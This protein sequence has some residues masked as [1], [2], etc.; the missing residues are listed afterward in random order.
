MDACELV[1]ED[2]VVE[3]TEG[4]PGIVILTV[5]EGRED[6]GQD[7]ETEGGLLAL[8]PVG[9]VALRGNRDSDRHVLRREDG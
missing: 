8:D 6:D 5:A 3:R 9:D 7:V 2:G 1:D 4:S